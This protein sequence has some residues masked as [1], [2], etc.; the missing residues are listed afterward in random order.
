[1]GKL[2]WEV[3][4]KINIGGNSKVGDINSASK[5]GIV[6]KVSDKSKVEPNPGFLMQLFKSLGKLFKGH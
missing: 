5:N 1:M 4:V 2:S 3:I 6:L